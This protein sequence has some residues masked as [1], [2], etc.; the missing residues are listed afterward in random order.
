MG[1]GAHRK[2]DTHNIYQTFDSTVIMSQ[3]KH[4]DS[5]I[6]KKDNNMGVIKLECGIM[7]NVQ[8]WV[9]EYT[10]GKL[11][12]CLRRKERIKLIISD[13]T[14][15]CPDNFDIIVELRLKVKFQV[16]HHI[17]YELLSK[18]IHQ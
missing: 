4:G 15:N 3:K 17:V 2:S 13:Q 12:E 14:R 8:F 10:N 9:K 16:H 5:I 6:R 1:N 18:I 11:Y 7:E